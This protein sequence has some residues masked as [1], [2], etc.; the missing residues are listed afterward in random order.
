MEIERS[1]IF[2]EIGKDVEE[3]QKL[4][5]IASRPFVKKILGE[6]IIKRQKDA[7]FS[8]FFLLNISPSFYVEKA[9]TLKAKGNHFAVSQVS[10]SSLP[11]PTVKITDYA[12]DESQKFVK[13]YLTLPNV[14][15]LPE[16]RIHISFSEKSLEVMVKDLM[17]KNYS[18]VIKGLAQ[19]INVVQSSFKVQLKNDMLL[20]MMKKAK[21]NE[22]WSCLTKADKDAKEKTKPK[23]DEHADPQESLMN[24]MKQMYEDGDDEMKRSIRKAWYESQNKVNAPPG[25]F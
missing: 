17:G 9:E 1:D 2:S 14:Q 20:I 7:C 18:L 13:L 3:L 4:L 5:S 16:D 15:S 10:S 21:E 25:D 8:H 24:M 11:L 19:P 23:V 6:L 12:W 22:G